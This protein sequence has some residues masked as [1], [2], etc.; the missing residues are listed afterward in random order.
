MNTIILSKNSL[1][2]THT[3]IKRHEELVVR[4]TTKYSIF[5]FLNGN[6]KLNMPHLK[7]LEIS[8]SA[9]QLIAP[10]IVNEYYQ[11]IDG[12]YRFTVCKKLNI[13]VYYLMLPNY[14]IEEVK[15]LNT[16]SS[17]W[18]KYDFLKMYCDMD[19]PEYQKF[20]QFMND[21]PDF[22]IASCE[23]LLTAKTGKGTIKTDKELRTESNKYGRVTLRDF[24]DG[25]LVCFNY[26]LSCEMA[27]K[28]LMIKPYSSEVYNRK[29]FVSAMMQMFK[30]EN[31][32]HNEFIQKLRQQPTSLVLCINVEQY[33]KLVEDIYNYR[34]RDKINL[35][36]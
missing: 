36:F 3:D 22:G 12:Q 5:S 19:Y 9:R 25:N 27:Q 1:N 15:I 6:R 26:E 13:P 24:E 17:N 7:R 2:T 21:Y 23:F 11:I 28:I 8:M 4:S 30:N 31:Y 14:G 16:N 20:R 10:I 33:K 35:R 18:T 29:E 32:D 34:R